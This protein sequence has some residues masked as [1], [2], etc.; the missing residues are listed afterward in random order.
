MLVDKRWGSECSAFSPLL[1][2]VWIHIHVYSVKTQQLSFH[3]IAS[4]EL[5]VHRTWLFDLEKC[6]T[7]KTPAGTKIKIRGSYS[8]VKATHLNDGSRRGSAGGYSSRAAVVISSPRSCRESSRSF[9]A[10]AFTPKWAPLG[11]TQKL[12]DRSPHIATQ[13]CENLKTIYL[14]KWKSVYS[15]NPSGVFA[16]GCPTRAFHCC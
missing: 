2:W 5:Q 7:V 13:L 6:H 16:S 8:G 1:G 4:A 12:Q 15:D 10:G 3:G 14:C 9:T 11:R